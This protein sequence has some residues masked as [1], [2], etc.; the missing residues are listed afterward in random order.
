MEKMNH[1]HIIM[2]LFDSQMRFGPRLAIL[3]L[4]MLMFQPLIAAQEEIQSKT[5]ITESI[6]Q[7]V[8][9][10]YTKG[11]KIKL[12]TQKLDPHLRLTHCSTAL[13]I[14]Y[15]VGS[16]KLGATTLGVRC[17]GDDPWKIYVPTQIHV[18]GPVVVSKRALPRG[19]ILHTDDVELA[20]RELSQATSGHYVLV[21]EL[22]GMILRRSLAKGSIIPPKALKQRHMVKRGDIIT[23]LAE[24][25]NVLIRVKGK[26]LMDG[27]RGQSIRIKNTRS[28]RELQGE[29]IDSGVV[30]VKL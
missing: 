19:T 1:T 26:A 3:C 23:I 29:V 13:E 15:P 12:K 30:K 27:Y 14:F 8:N 25:E 9:S 5:S 17:T 6:T 21:H 24:S 2:T 22:K 18:Y 4:A 7:F 10:Q 20:K 28:T 11:Y 16:R